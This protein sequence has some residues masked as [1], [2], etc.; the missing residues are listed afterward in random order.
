MIAIRQ[1]TLGD[2]Q[3]IPARH[4]FREQWFET[5]VRDGNCHVAVSDREIVG[6][7]IFAHT[8]FLMGFVEVIRVAEARRG[9]GIATALLR[10]VESLCTTDRIFAS[11][12][13]SNTPMH[14]LLPKLGY[15]PCGTIDLDP[16]DPEIVY[17]KR[18]KAADNT[19]MQATPD[20]APDG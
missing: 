15:A 1:A 19:S 13:V 6:H 7:V 2:L 14:N 18:L 12:N 4:P 8:F 11:T 9:E 10:H 16:G 3:A 5:H 20:G 17:V